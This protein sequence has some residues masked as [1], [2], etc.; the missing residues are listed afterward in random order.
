MRYCVQCVQPD[1]RPGIKFNEEGVCPACVY[2]ENA[3]SIDWE[4]RRKELLKIIEEHKKNNKLLQYDCIIGVSG[5]K[6]S[7]R[8]ALY[9]KE[10]LGLK[11][12]LVCC[13]YPPE[14][15]TER[16]AYNLANLISQGFDTISVSPSPQI[17]KR[18]VRQGFLKYGNWARSTEMALFASVPRIAIAYHIPLIFWGEN[19]ATQFGNL[20]VGSLNWNGNQMRNS[21]TISGGPDVLLEQDMCEN[22]IIWYRYPSPEEMEQAT[23]QI[24]YLGYF[25]KDWSKLNNGNFS[26]ARGLEIRDDP[27]ENQGALNPFDALDDDFVVVN[28]MI[29]HVKYGFGKVT[30]EVCEQIRAGTLTRA[31]GVELVKK[32]DGKCARSYIQR[33]CKYIEI[34]EDTFW[35]VVES[36]RNPEIWV[37]DPAGGWKLKCFPQ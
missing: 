18:L 10:V 13:T 32:Y 23:L 37:K 27:P 15:Q 4:E 31:E 34:S 1:T 6:D 22:E 8:Q 17:W 33:F 5:G 28:Q 7:T 24:V 35:E 30:D 9:V 20:G 29:K 11:P 21:N 14:Q 12:L 26:I 16:G 3:R 19:P 25:W 36:F 2:A